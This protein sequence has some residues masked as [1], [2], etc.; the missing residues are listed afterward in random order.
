M[1]KI[2]YE[3]KINSSSQ[4]VY[5]AMLGL[6]DKSTYEYWTS[7]FNP[8]STFEGSWNK[9]SKIHFIGLDEN[10]K[11]GGMVSEIVENKPADFVSIRHYGILDGENEITTGEKVEKWAGGLEN[12]KF[13]ENNGITTVIVELDVVDEYLDYFDNTYPSALDKL[14]EISEK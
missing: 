6:N 5:E 7:A 3:K 13:K 1:K 11:K 9:G 14:K 4:N 12:Y 10:G 8:T 2:K